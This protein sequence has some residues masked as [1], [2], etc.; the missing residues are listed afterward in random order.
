M[1]GTVIIHMVEI[2]TQPVTEPYPEPLNAQYKW[3][4]QREIERKPNYPGDDLSKVTPQ[5]PEVTVVTQQS[6]SGRTTQSSHIF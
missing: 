3:T 6:H 1:Q 5:L 2:H 4:R